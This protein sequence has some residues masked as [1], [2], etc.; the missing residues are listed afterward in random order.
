MPKKMS[1]M[2]DAELGRHVRDRLTRARDS[3]PGNVASSKEIFDKVFDALEIEDDYEPLERAQPHHDLTEPQ[4]SQLEKDRARAA[5]DRRIAADH[6]LE[7]HRIRASGHRDVEGQL[8][9]SRI[10]RSRGQSAAVNA[11]IP[12]LDRLK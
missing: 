1:E 6:A 3:M 7:E 8:H 11:A 12:G 4:G 5:H 2:N 9:L 10:L